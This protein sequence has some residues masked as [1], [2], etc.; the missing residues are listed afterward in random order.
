MSWDSSNPRREGVELITWRCARML[1]FTSKI[2]HVF[3]LDYSTLTQY[4]SVALN[5]SLCAIDVDSFVKLIFSRGCNSSYSYFSTLGGKI[6]PLLGARLWIA[7]LPKHRARIRQ[8]LHT[9][10][11][12]KEQSVPSCRCLKSCCSH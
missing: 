4:D 12:T 9:G 6:R 7:R 10:R 11:V 2:S 8:W 1:N 5:R 3:K